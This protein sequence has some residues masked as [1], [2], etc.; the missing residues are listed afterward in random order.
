M[1]HF[2][3]NG[4][5]EA[6]L[7]RQSIVKPDVIILATG[8]IPHFPF[9]NTDH[10]AGRTPYPVSHDADVRQVWSSSDPTIG[11]IGFIRPGFGAIPPLAEM[12][13]MLFATHLLGRIS[14]PL[15]KDDEWHYRVIHPPSA[16]VTYGVEH[17]SYA[18]QLAKDLDQAASF[19]DVFKLAFSTPRGW[20]LPYIW[21]GGASFTPKF[22]LV[23]PWR[24][25]QAGSILT[26]DL[27]ETI[28]RRHG[29]FGNI[30]MTIIPLFYLG[31]VNLAALLYSGF[32][33]SLAAIGLCRPVVP[34]NEVKMKFEELAA[35]ENMS[36]K[37]Q[38]VD[39]KVPLETSVNGTS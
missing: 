1:A 25:P 28:S 36:M 11:F 27:W 35:L 23:G 22:R 14:K 39:V 33:N 3:D 37:K 34:R 38:A 15:L 18:Y 6:T 30:P 16:R 8:Y 24:D 31:T 13:A 21:A 7:I 26:G 20:R 2:P 17:D 10:N 12:Q 19:T 4:R 5:A 9:L 32:W 29:L